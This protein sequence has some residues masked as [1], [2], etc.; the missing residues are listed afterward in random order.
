MVGVMAEGLRGRLSVEVL[1]EGD[2][3]NY[4]S[5]MNGDRRGFSSQKGPNPQE[6]QFN[7]ILNNSRDLINILHDNTII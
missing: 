4:G 1:G 6:I 5:G 7:W 2:I 3:Q